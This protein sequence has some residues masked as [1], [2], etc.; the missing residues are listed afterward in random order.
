M[1]LFGFNNIR[2]KEKVSK[3]F[4][5]FDETPEENES[6]FSFE[7][8]YKRREEQEDNLKKEKQENNITKKR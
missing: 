5:I 2:N 7:N 4:K 1:G 8:K 3:I 6:I